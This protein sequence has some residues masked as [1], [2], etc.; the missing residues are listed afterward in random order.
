MDDDAP[1]CE[2]GVVLS[3]PDSRPDWKFIVNIKMVL[4]LWKCIESRPDRGAAGRRRQTTC[5]YHQ[6][7]YYY[8]ANYFFLL[9]TA[10]NLM[11]CAVNLILN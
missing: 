3:S 11:S 9:I 5:G 4:V 7:Y 10:V 2:A 8:Q 1:C 6:Y